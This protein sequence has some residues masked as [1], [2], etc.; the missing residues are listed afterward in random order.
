MTAFEFNHWLFDR[1]NGLKSKNRKIL[2]LLDNCSAHKIT[3]EINNIELLFLPKNSMS[4]LQPLDAGIIRSF[5]A[6]YF[7]FQLS[8]LVNKITP[9]VLVEGLYKEITIK[10]VII[11]SKYACDDV[12]NETLIN[13]WNKVFNDEID[14]E[15]MTS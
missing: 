1:N 12:V 6:K 5:K 7:G 15:Q 2:F 10:D 14:A 9:G 8:S 13:C 3:S 11:Y 4:K